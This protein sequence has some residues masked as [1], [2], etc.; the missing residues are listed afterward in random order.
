M[1]TYKEIRER[2]GNISKHPGCQFKPRSPLVHEGFP[3]TFNLSFTEYEYEKE[4]GDLSSFDHDFIYSTIQS[5]VRPSDLDGP[6]KKRENLERYLGVFEMADIGGQIVLSDKLRTSECYRHQLKTMLRILEDLGLEKNKIFPSY[7]A[8]GSVSESSHGKYN[9]NFEVPEDSLS[10]KE[11]L[12]AG[13]P[14]EN[15]IEDKTRDTFL[16]LHIN[17]KTPWGYRNEIHYNVGTPEAPVLLDIA[18]LEHFYWFPTYSSRE[19]ASKNI[20]GLEEIPHTISIGAFGLERLCMATNGLR[21]VQDVDYLKTFYDSFRELSP[22]MKET[23][24][25]I[26]GEAIRAI[27]RIQSDITEQNLYW[28]KS[29]KKK[30]NKILQLIRKNFVEPIDSKKLAS[31]LKIHSEVQPW[32]D[33]LEAG[34]KPTVELIQ[35]YLLSFRGKKQ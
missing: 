19:E 6:I 28:S 26:G 31:L 29:R 8:G 1:V 27:H 30:R 17:K 32:H 18:T 25:I 5:C 16:C 33:N 11:F 15:L 10:K 2:I 12:S 35:N 7:H 14:K 20:D 34:I 22:E 4:F 23:Q 9:F 13:I 3:G 21:K 24:R